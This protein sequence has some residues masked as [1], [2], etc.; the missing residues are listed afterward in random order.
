MRRV[1]AAVI[2][3]GIFGEIHAATY[4]EDDRVDLAMVCDLNEERAKEIGEKYNCPYVT[5]SKAIAENQEVEIASIA[6]PDF[7][8]RDVAIEIASSGKHILVEKPLATKVED[9]E[10]IIAAAK[11]AK[12]KMSLMD[13][14][15]SI[16]VGKSITPRQRRETLIPEFPNLTYSIAIPLKATQIASA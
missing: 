9:A 2:G 1:K 7:A 10:A 8:H 12:V 4:A 16:L 14:F 3:V 5:N 6:T 15:L 11:E 13:S